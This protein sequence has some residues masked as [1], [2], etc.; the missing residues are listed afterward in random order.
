MDNRIVEVSKFIVNLNW[1]H[2]WQIWSERKVLRHLMVLLIIQNKSTPSLQVGNVP[3]RIQIRPNNSSGT[4]TFPKDEIYLF[5][6]EAIHQVLGEGIMNNFDPYQNRVD[7]HLEKLRTEKRNEKDQKL[8]KLFYNMLNNSSNDT[9][10]FKII[11][12]FNE[13]FSFD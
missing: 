10:P 1:K 8:V 7:G 11:S 13:I 12:S 3:S 2:I 4:S 6:Q 9:S 5:V